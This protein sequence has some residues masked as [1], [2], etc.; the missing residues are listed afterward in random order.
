MFVFDVTGTRPA[1]TADGRYLVMLNAEVSRE[2]QYVA[3]A[4]EPAHLFLG[5]L[6]TGDEGAWWDEG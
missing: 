3:L 1:R 5:H 6:D 2:G 4:H